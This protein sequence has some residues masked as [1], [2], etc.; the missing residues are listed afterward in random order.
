MILLRLL[1]ILVVLTLIFC[2][3]AYV[4]TRDA[5]YLRLAQQVL[6]LT[7]YLV[8]LLGLLYV[9]ERYVLSGWGMLV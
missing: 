9:V 1:F 5:R 2:G 3:G 7:G 8:L 4:L 6:R